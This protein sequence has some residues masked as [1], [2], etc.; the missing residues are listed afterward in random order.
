MPSV[1]SIDPSNLTISHLASNI[2][3]RIS[4]FGTNTYTFV[5]SF[6]T[7]LNSPNFP[8]DVFSFVIDFIDACRTA[9]VVPQSLTLANVNERD[10]SSFVFTAFED[11]IDAAV[12]P[13]P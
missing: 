9:T 4:L 7:S 12:T 8:P 1:F 6:A 13:Y 10:D 11:S 5:G 3:D 2:A